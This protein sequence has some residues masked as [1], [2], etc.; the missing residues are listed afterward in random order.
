MRY[1]YMFSAHCRFFKASVLVVSIYCIQVV[2]GIMSSPPYCVLPV[3]AAAARLY[4][5]SCRPLL[6]G[7]KFQI[8]ACALSNVSV[9]LIEIQVSE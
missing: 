2:N 1:L 8:I 9:R 5:T 4:S 6:S 7:P 3:S